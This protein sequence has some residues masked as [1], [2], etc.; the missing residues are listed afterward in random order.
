VRKSVM[1]TCVLVLGSAGVSEAKRPAARG[2][3]YIDGLPCN[4]LCL[5]YMHWSH[6]LLSTRTRRAAAQARVAKASPVVSNSSQ[7]PRARIADLQPAANAAAVSEKTATD[8][9]DPRRKAVSGAGSNARTIQEQV[10]AATAAAM[11]VMGT[12]VV[13]PEQKASHTGASDH[14]EAVPPADARKSINDG[15]L[16]IVLVMAR[17]EI[18]SV[19]DLA[20][21]TIAID[22]AQSASSDNVR[23]AIVAAGAT[24]IEL[25]DGQT[26]A[27]D[28]LVS[29]VV[30]A[31]V[32]AVVS[33]E[34]ALRFP[35]IK[36]FR[37]F[38]V[39]L[40]PRSLKA[41]VGTPEA[42]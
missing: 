4:S 34:A 36:G 18:R 11:Q 12:A 27:I 20:S 23:A 9:A 40:L 37:I 7:V 15:D 8:I 41:A 30:P 3:A 17:P 26:K 32:L 5:S 6:E 14:P 35:D 25:S 31:A 33:P 16:L 10:T 1:L 42:K 28:R 13:A 21:K 29:G 2:M 19:S 22:D 39:L 38:Q 24:E